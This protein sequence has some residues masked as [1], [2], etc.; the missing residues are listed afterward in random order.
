MTTSHLAPDQFSNLLVIAPGLF[1]ASQC[2]EGKAA[3]V[4]G[5]PV[6]GID[7]DGL[8]VGLYGCCEL[9]EVGERESEI[10]VSVA[11]SLIQRQR[12]TI[13]L[14]RPRRVAQAAIRDAPVVVGNRVVR[15]QR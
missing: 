11:V 1:P 4:I 15:G 8:R 9:A 2:P 6:M 7:G 14:K 3:I 5:V 12:L 13:V 10:V